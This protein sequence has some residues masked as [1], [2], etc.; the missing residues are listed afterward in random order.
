MGAS[1]DGCLADYLFVIG[2]TM[3]LTSIHI[4]RG[5][6]PE[7]HEA[8]MEQVYLS[9]Y[10][11]LGTP[12]G[13]KFMTITEHEASCFNNSG[14]HAGIERSDDTVIIQIT[15]LA[16]RSVDQKKALYAALAEKLGKDPGVRKEDIFVS[17][18]E[19]AKEDFSLG[20][21]IAQYA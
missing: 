10:E 12:E 6:S 21:G 18:I 16:G 15:I 5:K 1:F 19:C 7:Y 8:L 4:R 2:K 11:A 9:M 20:N 13:D 17:L 3:P 14:N